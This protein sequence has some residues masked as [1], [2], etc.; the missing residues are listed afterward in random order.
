MRIPKF[1]AK[2]WISNTIRKTNLK[3]NPKKILDQNF[4]ILLKARYNNSNP[5]TLNI[6]SLT[7]MKTVSFR[8]DGGVGPR[9]STLRNMINRPTMDL[10]QECGQN[11]LKLVDILKYKL[12]TNHNKRGN[13]IDH[14]QIGGLSH[15]HVP[16][17]EVE[18]PMIAH[19]KTKSLNLNWR[20]F[21]ERLKDGWWR[22]GKLIFNRCF[23]LSL[24]YI[25]F[26]VL[27]GILSQIDF[28]S[29]IYKIWTLPSAPSRR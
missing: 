14:H 18:T 29:V 16:I 6:H 13:I 5:K 23:F 19:S 10:I 21:K 28:Y 1:R 17:I 3:L 11:Q 27:V 25:S 4:R 22:S 2:K 26:L 24:F 9:R 7:R 20:K 8:L 15:M 12:E